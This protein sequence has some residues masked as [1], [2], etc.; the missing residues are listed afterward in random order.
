VN[1][2]REREL[3]LEIDDPATARAL[4]RLIDI[5]EAQDAL[6]KTLVR[7]LELDEEEPTPWAR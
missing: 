1:L 7:L 2:D 5:I 4:G 3:L 6:V